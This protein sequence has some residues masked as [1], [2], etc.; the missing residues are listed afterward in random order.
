VVVLVSMVVQAQVYLRTDLYYVLME[1]LRGRNLYQDGIAYARHLARRA[2]RRPSVDP[3]A[4]LPARERRGV[5]IYA[6][7]MAGGCAVALGSFALF[8]LP[9]LVQ[10]IVGAFD[11]L[12]H[13][14]DPLRMVDSAL[15]ILVEGALQ[16]FFVVTFVR[17]HRHWF[18]RRARKPVV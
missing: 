7:F 17:V 3:V 5:R 14:G 1:W 4:G 9:I 18:R 15:V 10:G 12:L 8:G 16:V 11:G 6:V 2:L 13:S